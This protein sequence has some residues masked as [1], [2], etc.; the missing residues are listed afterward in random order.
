MIWLVGVL[1]THHAQAR[2]NISSHHLIK[3]VSNH[4]GSHPEVITSPNNEMI[5]RIQS[6]IKLPDTFIKL[7]ECNGWTPCTSAVR[8]MSFL[9][10]PAG[11][12]SETCHLI[13][14]PP[15]HPWNPFRS[16]LLSIARDVKYQ[17]ERMTKWGGVVVYRGVNT[18]P[19]S[20][21]SHW[22]YLHIIPSKMGAAQ[23]KNNI[24][25]KLKEVKKK[26]YPNN[27]NN[28]VFK[29]ETE[30]APSAVQTTFL[31]N[32]KNFFSILSSWF[33]LVSE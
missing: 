17:Q 13:W 10:A 12:S 15:Q 31:S 24:L 9:K 20:Q 7:S 1:V 8:G 11:T 29:K 25:F 19:R 5:L 30:R 26:Y 33:F 6:L 23:K 14:E 3:A 32:K 27:Y 28:K 4:I 21:H 2:N 18:S 16:A 22:S